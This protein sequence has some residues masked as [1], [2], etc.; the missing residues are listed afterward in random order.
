MKHRCIISRLKEPHIARMYVLD[1]DQNLINNIRVLCT[2]S[3]GTVRFFVPEELF[4]ELRN[5]YPVPMTAECLD[6]KGRRLQLD[7]LKVLSEQLREAKGAVMDPEGIEIRLCVEGYTL[8]DP[9]EGMGF[10]A[11]T[12]RSGKQSM[13]DSAAGYV[14]S[15][16]GASR[17]RNSSDRDLSDRDSSYRKPRRADEAVPVHRRPVRRST[18][19]TAVAAALF[20]LAAAGFWFLKDASV[21]RFE[22]ALRTA[23]YSEAVWIYNEKIL[24]HPSG[25]SKADPQFESAVSDIESGYLSELKRYDEAREA[26]EILTGIGKSELSQLAQSAL[27][28][29]EAYEQASALYLEGIAAMGIGDYVDAI[30]AF[31]S[32]IVP[33]R[34]SEDQLALSIDRLIKS[35]VGIRTEEEYPDAA[36]KIEEAIGLLPEHEALIEAR[37]ACRSKYEQL[38][39]QNAVTAA[40][41]KIKENDYAGA[42]GLMT[43]ALEK[44]GKNDRLEEKT[45]EYRKAFTAYVTKE[46]CSKVDEGDTDGAQSLL[47]ESL[48]ILECDQFESLQSQVRAV[49][50][51][52]DPD[53]E[54]YYAD[55]APKNGNRGSIREK[56]QK[57][58][59]EIVA[60]ES[61]PHRF[62]LSEVRKGLAVR[63]TIYAEDGDEIYAGGVIGSGPR[64]ADPGAGSGKATGGKSAE[65]SVSR[66]GAGGADPGAGA[67]S[68]KGAG[69]ETGSDQA[70]GAGKGA[71]SPASG[72]D[73]GPGE[74]SSGS[75]KA[76]GPDADRTAAGADPDGTAAGSAD[77]D[78]GRDT[79]GNEGDFGS[80]STD[81][82]S[83]TGAAAGDSV[84]CKLEAGQKYTVE[85]AGIEGK[86]SYSLTVR[87]QKPAADLTA[88]DV[89]CDRMEFADQ[90]TTYLFTPEQS[91]M[92][93]LDLAESSEL[94]GMR[95]AFYDASGDRVAGAD[96]A[97]GEGLS[98]RLDAGEEYE[99]LASE[100][101]E[102]GEY[103][104]RLG[105][106]S[107]SQD[108]TGQNI[109]VGAIHYTDQ[110]NVYKYTAEADVC[111]R[112]TIGNLPEDSRVG[113]DIYDSLGYKIGGADSIQNGESVT[114]EPEA[115]QT[116][117]IR[118]TQ[119][120]G[121]GEYTLTV[122]EEEKG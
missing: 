85:I 88:Y 2:K 121:T 104:L 102:I 56:G 9:E 119:R 34:D 64:G 50:D 16:A 81:S 90:Q 7:P 70:T 24:G 42:F 100:P 122:C 105:K 103:E 69:S 95:V 1:F 58:R 11:R 49:D 113:L 38:V 20:L 54:I 86:G 46:V 62:L 22:E 8:P 14:G 43:A 89:V 23:K 30:R 53:P 59:Y 10:L 76:D 93:R 29:V 68:G 107:P 18:V 55:R 39:V 94:S 82:D 117:E 47:E 91:G 6:R 115:G 61:G 111:L 37:G 41:K 35:C 101:S 106:P 80:G 98:V 40:E 92:Y 26:L 52:E 13:E 77:P 79:S 51:R 27:G 5:G 114:V 108:L 87:E 15:A 28:D 120:S 75:V 17:Q 73:A 4:L 21:R 112:F 97:D 36:A 66:E 44:T 74:G 116:C 96:L 57:D 72:A 31:S 67:D 99:I 45:A 83:G 118:V 60:H 71:G 19:L 84:T 3:P 48:Q 32:M 25:E 12:P 65:S 110:R 109:A 63:M 78:S 33:C